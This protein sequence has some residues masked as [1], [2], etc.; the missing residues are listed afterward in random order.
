MISYDK[1]EIKE[2][3]TLENIFEI[4]DEWGGNPMYNSTG[5]VCDTIDHNVPGEGSRKLYYYENSSLFTSYTSGYDAFD[6]FEL[7]IKVF[8]IQQK[9]EIDLNEAVR[10]IAFRFGISGTFTLSEESEKLEDWDVLKNYSRVK[11]IEQKNYNVILKEYDSEILKIFNQQLKIIPWL[12][13]EISQEVMDKNEISF[14]AGHNQIVIPHYDKDNRLIGI[15]GRTLSLEDAEMYGK[16]RPLIVGKTQ[17]NHPLG[18]NLYN[19]NNSQENIRNSGRAILFESEKS[20]LKYQSYFGFDSDIS[21]ACCGSNLSDYQAHLLMALGV[22]EIIIALDRQFQAIGDKEFL[23][24]KKN[25]LNLYKKYRN[26][27][28]ISFMFDKNMITDYKASP[29]DEGI[30]KFMKL[31]KERIV[32]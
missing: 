2:T 12:K 3:L 28:K 21:V 23:K 7:T 15:R 30:D 18:M 13:E 6:I 25:L 11:N 16:Y 26:Y 22:K 8:N 9:K 27:V 24:L 10:Y 4:L 20:C 14:Y 19:L 1:K 32:L 31:Y 17:F 29:I 5:I